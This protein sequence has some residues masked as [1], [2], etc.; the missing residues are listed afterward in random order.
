MYALAR[1]DQKVSPGTPS[2]VL[3]QF[4]EARHH[5]FGAPAAPRLLVWTRQQLSKRIAQVERAVEVRER[6]EVRRLKRW[7]HQV[8]PAYVGLRLEPHAVAG[9]G[10]A[11]QKR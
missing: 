4:K 9:D 2:I 10:T 3:S 8:R 7:L 11:G 1:G 6:R 5:M